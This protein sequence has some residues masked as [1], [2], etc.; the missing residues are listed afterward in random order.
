MKGLLR[1]DFYMLWSYCKSL[2]LLLLVFSLVSLVE[3]NSFYTIYPVMVGS[4]LPVTIISYEERCKWTVYCQTLPLSRKTVVLEKY[5]LST[6]CTAGILFLS[7]VTQCIALVRQDTFSWSGYLDQM[8]TLLV[9]ALVGPSITLPLIFK[10][11]SEKGRYGYYFVIGGACAI[12]VIFS[13]SDF[14]VIPVPGFLIPLLALTLYGASCLLSI[15][16]YQKREL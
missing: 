3:T 8:S 2:L 7:A 10:L 9:F 11:G 16:F 14:P 5:A 4:I 13:K 1:K 15:H 12:S 6:I